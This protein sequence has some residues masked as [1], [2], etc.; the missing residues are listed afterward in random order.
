[1]VRNN[2]ILPSGETVS[3]HSLQTAGNGGGKETSREVQD[4]HRTEV[5]L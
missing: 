4:I 3:R 5:A 1:M 2:E